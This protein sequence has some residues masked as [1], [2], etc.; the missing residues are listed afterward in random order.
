MA[1]IDEELD[2]ADT[3]DTLQDMANEA[4]DGYDRLQTAY[5][6]PGVGAQT[7]NKDFVSAEQASPLLNLYSPRLFGA[8]PQ[9]T[10]ACD[11]R[12]ISSNGTNPGPVGDFYLT[13][14]LREAQ[15]ANFVVGKARFMGGVSSLTNLIYEAYYYGAALSKY[16]IFDS[17]GNNVSSNNQNIANEI[18]SM[19]NKDTFEKSLSED[20]TE[21][22]DGI[23]RLGK[24]L[25]YLTS[26]IDDDMT[27]ADITKYSEATTIGDKLSG[28][29]GG[30][31]GISAAFLTSMS[32][33]KNFYE[34]ESNWH[35]YINNVKMMINTAVIMLGLQRACV[36]VG[37]YYYPIGMDAKVNKES[38]VW[39][40]YRYITPVS[41]LG[42]VTAL[43][44]ANGD[45]SQYVSFM[46]DANGLSESYTNEV[47]ASQIYSNVISKG[48]EVGSEIAFIAS[49]SSG[50]IND[51][52]I[53]LA[54]ES[55]V[56]AEEVLTTLQ[57]GEGKFTAAIAS[58]MSRSFTG[59]HTIYPDIFKSH[60]STQSLTL[61]VHLVASGG[62][63]YSY[64]TDELVP[65][66]FILGMALPQMS[67]NSAGAY[68]YPPVIQCHIPGI[69]GTRLGMVTSVTVNKNPQGKDLSVHGY[70]LSMD[71]SI[72]V[73]DL[74]HALGTSPMD[75]PS[76]MLN[77]K[78]MF[79][80]I[81]QLSGV[82]KYRVNG[83]MRTITRLALAASAVNPKNM[84]YNIG[85]TLLSDM[86]SLVNKGSRVG[87]L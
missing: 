70:P 67:K 72:T 4:V 86:A 15:V 69:W 82:D 84:M 32:V 44:T 64:L 10:H 26:E 36:R 24:S 16:D 14:I 19:A 57:S 39:A 65:L 21:T 74:Q 2:N 29:L 20:V 68:T 42:T 25:S 47:G 83:S 30:L 23:L 27:V 46:V 54:T 55:R 53:D 12:L 41:N 52:M 80:Y 66:F 85:S 73:A 5:I 18:H 58:A 79:D 17:D 35:S 49:A 13:K 60:S 63:P 87:S 81:A 31:A 78:P 75:Q 33:N 59:D 3:Q 77:N 45:N 11:M 50:M 38:D 48:N 34:F 7:N 37:D 1:V 40:N 56:A 43:D 71:I 28:A 76:V 6:L 61:T 51:K 9:L 62:D 8:P 22:G